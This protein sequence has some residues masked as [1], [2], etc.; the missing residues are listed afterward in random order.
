MRPLTFGAQL[1]RHL[2]ICSASVS[3]SAYSA[4][5]NDQ[6]TSGFLLDACKTW[7]RFFERKGLF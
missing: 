2:A 3:F 5:E 6:E 7:V 1:P 4:S